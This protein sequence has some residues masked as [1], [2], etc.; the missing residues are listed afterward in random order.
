[1]S[2]FILLWAFVNCRRKKKYDTG[3]A[4]DEPNRHAPEYGKVY[5]PDLKHWNHYVGREPNAIVAF[6]KNDPIGNQLSAA[7][8]KVLNLIDISKLNVVV[9][10]QEKLGQIFEDQGITEIP[11]IKFYKSEQKR[12]VKTYEGMPSAKAISKWAMDQVHELDDWDQ[13]EDY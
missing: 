8:G 7:M 1:M 12:W 13:N 3:D 5:F 9:A 11:T 2:G 10:Q 4:D 6:I